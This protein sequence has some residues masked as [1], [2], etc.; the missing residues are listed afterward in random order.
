MLFYCIKLYAVAMDQENLM[1]ARWKNIKMTTMPTFDIVNFQQYRH[2]TL[3]TVEIV[4]KCLFYQLWH[5]N[6]RILFEVDALV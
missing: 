1:D 3:A 4:E 2:L 6:L 5:L